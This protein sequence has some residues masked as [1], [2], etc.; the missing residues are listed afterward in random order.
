[1]Q[2]K[3]VLPIILDEHGDSEIYPSYEEAI[4]AIEAIDVRNNEYCGYDAGGRKL[5]LSVDDA[6]RITM[7]LAE[8]EPS[9]QQE[10]RQVLIKH[11]SALKHSPDQLEDKSIE[12]LLQLAPKYQ[13][14]QQQSVFSSLAAW[15]KG[16]L[17]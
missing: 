2:A 7:S 13:Y 16:L 3:I 1:M 5:V 15:F 14:T 12:E 9:H 6:D 11:L 8:Q 4:M 17:K 10:L